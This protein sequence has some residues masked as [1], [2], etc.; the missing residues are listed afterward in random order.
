M[1]GPLIRP[2]TKREVVIGVISLTVAIGIMALAGSTGRLSSEVAEDRR[3]EALAQQ[4]QAPVVEATAS[5][6][7][8]D[9][10]A[11]LTDPMIVAQDQIRQA[12][13]GGD[14]SE[15][16]LDAAAE[17]VKKIDEGETMS[18]CDTAQPE[19]SDVIHKAVQSVEDAAADELKEIEAK[20]YLT[21]VAAFIALAQ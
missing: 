14:F 18:K 2:P 19:V 4:S 15:T 5:A 13:T 16:D 9:V 21:D 8:A 20:L 1:P 7:C 6:E 11:E 12:S 3:Q 17:D 10:V